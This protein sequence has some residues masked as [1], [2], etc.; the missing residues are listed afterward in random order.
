MTLLVFALAL[1]AFTAVSLRGGLV[2]PRGLLVHSLDRQGLLIGLAAFALAVWFIG[3]LYGIA[4]TLSIIVHEFGHVAAYRVA[5]HSDARFRLLPLIGGVAISNRRPE[6]QAQDFFITLMGPGICIAPM[7]LG[8]ALAE[9]LAWRAPALAEAA[10]VFAIV[11][12]ALN[13]F[14]LLPFWPL[15]GGRC[16]SLLAQAVW[17]PLGRAAAYAMS[18]A[19]AAC[20]LWLQSTVLFFVALLA[21]HALLTGGAGASRQPPMSRAQVWLAGGAYLFTAAAHFLG[22]WALLSRFLH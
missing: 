15:D 8:F 5:G 1:C 20:A 12:G 22:G 4:L 9:S 18:A 21:A 17:Q 7:V 19:F 14:N 16:V 2:A 13:F 6:T 3:P 11:T 10:W